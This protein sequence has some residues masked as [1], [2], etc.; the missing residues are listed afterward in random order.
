MTLDGDTQMLEMA[1][2]TDFIGTANNSRYTDPK[3]N[4]MF[5]EARVT[6]DKEKRAEIFNQILTKAQN[7]AIYAVLCNPLTLYAYNSD[8]KCP[9]FPFEALYSIYDFSW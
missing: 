4:Q 5:D 9:E 6:N 2:T 7:E 1:Y 3:M 8:L